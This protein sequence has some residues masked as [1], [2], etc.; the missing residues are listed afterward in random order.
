MKPRRASN[1]RQAARLTRA[2][3][4]S[5]C[6]A[7]LGAALPA[8]ASAGGLLVAPTRIDAKVFP[9]AQLPPIRLS[10]RTDTALTVTVLVARARQDLAGLPVFDTSRRSRRQ[11]L[12]L[13]RAAPRRLHLAPGATA[14]VS[15]SVVRR[16]GRRVGAYA[17]VAFTARA[18]NAARKSGVAPTIR[19]TSN[20]LLQFPGRVRIA[21]HVSA[22]RAEQGPE[23]TLR[24][25]G[26]LRNTGNLHTR[27]RARLTLRTA[28]GR[29][30]L[31]RRFRG[32]T[33]LPGAERELPLTVKKILPAGEYTARVV[34]RV[35]RR[36]SGK[37]IRFRLI[38]PNELPTPALQIVSFPNPQPDPSESFDAHVKVKNVGTGAFAPTGTLIVTRVGGKRPIAQKRLELD[39][40]EP[41]DEGEA[42]IEL[43][44]LRKRKY[45]LAVR[46]VDAG[47]VLAERSLVFEPGTRPSLLTRLM[48]WIAAHVVGLLLLII[49]LLAGALMALA[50]ERG[51]SL[52]AR[53]RDA[54]LGRARQALTAMRHAWD[55]R[56]SGALAA[57][58]PRQRAQDREPPEDARE[59][60]RALRGPAG[61]MAP[62]RQ[63]DPSL[64]ARVRAAWPRSHAPSRQPAEDAL[65]H[66][67][68]LGGPPALM[69]PPREED[70]NGAG[71]APPPG[72]R[73]A[74]PPYRA[75][76]SWR[77]ACESPPGPRAPRSNDADVSS[78]ALAGARPGNKAPRSGTGGREQADSRAE[79]HNP[80]HQIDALTMAR[81]RS[82]TGR[83]ITSALHRCASKRESITLAAQLLDQ[84]KERPEVFSEDHRRVQ[85]S[86]SHF[87]LAIRGIGPKTA[88]SILQETGLEPG[89]PLVDLGVAEH[90]ALRAALLSR[91]PAP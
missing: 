73:T 67:R 83:D 10:N 25:L 2:L 31:R 34:A 17:V 71:M 68:A 64:L 13:L 49:A 90:Q 18:A 62:S 52:L 21:G 57:S 37:E 79:L 77:D 38:G 19:L 80:D 87:L 39:S 44:G 24:F 12:K 65:E 74:E 55:Q 28:D 75:T 35:G 20:L 50:S 8:S 72:Q 58:R 82:L 7:L 45:H 30:V 5:L 9:G 60:A 48:D 69:R 26:R 4:V 88:E 86:V 6:C 42:E 16:P 36:R 33:V 23:R 15:A 91:S 27:P 51:R 41:G 29:T 14:F 70:R 56:A 46:F 85:V 47:R 61:L 1:P 59:R 40:L 22:V 32:E 43:P 54:S 84:L 53:A 63:E 11:G 78:A 66:A 3:A 89:K 76:F 81:G